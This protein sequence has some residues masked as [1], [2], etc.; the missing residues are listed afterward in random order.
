MGSGD[1]VPGRRGARRRRASRGAASTGGASLP[2]GHVVGDDDVDVLRPGTGLAPALA[3]ALVGRR[4]GRKVAAGSMVK[5]A[6]LEGSRDRRRSGPRRS[7]SSRPGARTGGSCARRALAIRDET[8]VRLDVVAGGTHRSAAHGMTI[9][10]I[11]DGRLRADRSS[12]GSRA[13]SRPTDRGLDAR[14]GRSAITCGRPG[15]MPCCSSAIAT[16]RRRPPSPRRSSASRSPTS[17]A[18]SRRWA[19]S[20]TSC[21]TRSRSSPT[22]TS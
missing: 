8:D 3:G 22:S 20:T 11:R 16:R 6:D 12:R 13:T 5:A 17:T 18:A 1:K 10:G 21:A 4:T 2:A 15:P 7:R 19:R 14:C 9:D